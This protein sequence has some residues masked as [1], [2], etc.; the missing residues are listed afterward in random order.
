MTKR[1]LLLVANEFQQLGPER[2]QCQR[3]ASMC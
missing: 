2:T 3:F 1:N